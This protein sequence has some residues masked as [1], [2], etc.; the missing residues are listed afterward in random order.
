[1]LQIYE[2]YTN[3]YKLFINSIRDNSYVHIFYMQWK[4][5]K[6]NLLGPHQWTDISIAGVLIRDNKALIVEFANRP[7]KWDI[8]GGRIDKGETPD[9]GFK[10][11]LKEELGLDN[12][13]DLGIIDYDLW[14][15]S[16]NKGVACA[17]AH[18]IK[19]D[20]DEI[21]LSDEHLQYKWITEDEIDKYDALWPQYH[22]FLKKAFSYKRL[23]E[24]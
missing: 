8:P 24:K 21:K 11:E 16:E 2:S 7:G 19:N 14:Y 15:Y 6:K 9:I 23:L 20:T 4:N 3:N 13:E 17:I 18:L 1:M 22:R 5:L 10:R 12:F